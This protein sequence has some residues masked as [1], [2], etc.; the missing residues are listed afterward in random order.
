M[1]WLAARV[2]LQLARMPPLQTG[3]GACDAYAPRLRLRQ[4]FSRMLWSQNSKSRPYIA[5]LC[6]TLIPCDPYCAAFGCV[7]LPM[8]CFVILRC[9][10][11]LLV[12]N[13]TGM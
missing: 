5:T 8:L 1:A 7:V 12:R 11:L 13:A 3:C 4:A 6:R 9:A 10:V 2:S